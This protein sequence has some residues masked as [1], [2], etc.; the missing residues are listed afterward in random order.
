ML[1]EVGSTIV[2]P[3]CSSPDGLG[4]LDHPGGDAVLHRAAGVE[5]L[6]LGQHQRPGRASARR[7]GSVEGPGEP[8][9]RG[10]ADQVEERVHVLHPANLE[11]CPIRANVRAA[12]RPLRRVSAWGKPVQHASS[13][14]PPPSAAA[15]SRVLGAGLYG[16]LTAEAKLARRAIGDDPRGAAARR[17][18][19]VRPRPARP[20]DQDRAARRLQRRR[21]RR[22]P[23]RGDARR[24]AGHRARRARRPPGPPARVRRRRRPV[25]A[26]SAARSTGPC[27]IEPDVAVILIGANDVTHRML[28]SASVRHLLRGACAGC[29]TPASRSSSAPAPTSAPSSRSPPPLKQVARAWSRRL[30][31]A[32]TIAVRRGGRPHGLAGLD[33]RAGVRGRARRCCSAPTGSTRRPTATARWPPCCCPRRWPRSGW[34]PT[35]RPIP[36]RS[37]ARAS[38]RSP[39]PRSRPST[40]RHRARRHRGGRRP[41]RRPRPLGRAA[42]PPPR[43]TRAQRARPRTWTRP[44]RA[45]ARAVRPCRGPRAQSLLKIARIRSRLV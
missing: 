31:A 9:Q 34:S 23:G 27:P 16:V 33:P 25:L 37:A 44:D 38:C 43:A 30:A 24:A 5:V 11:P 14:P 28:P 12:Q 3:G 45:A 17:D 10:V 32:Q 19:L 7:R 22:R 42:P 4:G 13:R 18:R 39:R 29:A 36:R 8:Q 41:P 35:T 20:G 2:P 40:P 15:A 21:L 6:D 1:P 26:T